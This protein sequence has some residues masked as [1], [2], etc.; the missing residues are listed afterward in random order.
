VILDPEPKERPSPWRSY[1]ACV[2]AATLEHHALIIQD[3]AQ[4]HRQVLELGLRM[5]N[6]HPKRLI[7]LYHGHYPQNTA[8]R[9][10]MAADRG[11]AYAEV[12]AVGFV[13]CVALIWPAPLLRRL[14]RWLPERTVEAD[15]EM[16][17]NF[18]SWYD[19]D[20]YLVSVPCL[21]EHD[22]TVSSLMGTDRAR[23]AEYPP[24]KDASRVD[25]EGGVLPYL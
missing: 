22:D 6:T 2:A 16:I 15:D 5:I 18:L 12:R 8:I 10:H 3:D 1:K 23:P 14:Q 7:C 13:P 20:T 4:P 17:R 11:L 25:W 19:H 9:M 24:P 21:V